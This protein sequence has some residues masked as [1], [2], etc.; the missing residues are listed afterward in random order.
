MHSENGTVT[1][2]RQND[3]QITKN[4]IKPASEA[5]GWKRSSQSIGP[6]VPPCTVLYVGGEAGTP[7]VLPMARYGACFR[8]WKSV[9]P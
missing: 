2:I 1:A 3:R 6:P 5:S 7:F 9:L 4:S 8:F